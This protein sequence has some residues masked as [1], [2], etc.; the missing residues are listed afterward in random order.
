VREAVLS[1]AAR[2]SLGLTAIRSTQ[3]SLDEIYRAAL[4][5]AGLRPSAPEATPTGV[6]A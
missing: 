6:P 3:A 2:E 5:Q 4:H 1:A